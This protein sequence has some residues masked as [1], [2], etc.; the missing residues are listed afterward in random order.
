[1]RAPDG[2]LI[3]V[4]FHR[5]F[6]LLRTKMPLLP[7]LPHATLSTFNSLTMGKG[8]KEEKNYK[9]LLHDTLL[10]FRVQNELKYDKK[11]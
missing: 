11:A 3:F 9:L 10:Y 7:L 1:M 8:Q 4:P 2:A 5:G 6:F